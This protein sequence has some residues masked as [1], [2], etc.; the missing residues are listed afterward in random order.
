MH[1]RRYEPVKYFVNSLLKCDFLQVWDLRL[2]KA[3]MDLKENDDFISD[4]VV[5]SDS[6]VLVAS[7]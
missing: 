1:G 6:R 4:M 7:R 2:Q 3:V 5:D